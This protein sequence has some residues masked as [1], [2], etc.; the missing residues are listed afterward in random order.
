MMWGM[1]TVSMSWAQ[2]GGFNLDTRLIEGAAEMTKG[3]AGISLQEEVAIG[4]AVAV[5]I[6][7]Q[8]GG[9]D[10]D[11]SRTQRVALI[12][13]TLARYCSRPQ[14]N[15]RFAVLNSDAV[16]GVSV[17][18]GFVFLTRGLVKKIKNDHELAGILAHEIAHITQRHALKIISRGKFMKGMVSVAASQSSEF[19]MFD[20]GVDALLE[21]LTSKGF[22]P[23]TEYEADRVG[24]QLATDA[25]YQRNGLLDFLKT[26][27]QENPDKSYAFSTHPPLKHRV[28]R[29]QK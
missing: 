26:L 28:E 4:D 19:G 27:L 16:N 12:G 8:Y 9:L 21:T 7:A 29:L 1:L 24:R 3:A 11:E 15:Y 2:F 25:G 22:D 18:G 17:P 23:A 10:R 6:V 5:K 14:L 13:K 20:Q